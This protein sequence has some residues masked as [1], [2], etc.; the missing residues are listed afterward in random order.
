MDRRTN[1]Y[2]PGAGTPPPELVGRD[3][4]I[5]DAEIALDR[6]R[7][8][9]ATK[10]LLMV[11]LRGV[12]KTVLLNRILLDA[13]ER[14]FASVLIEAPEDRS[15]P[16]ALAGPLNSAFLQLSRSAAARELARKAR[17]SLAGFV[18]AMKV[19]YEDITF[20]VDLD[21]EEGVADSGDLDTDLAALLQVAG[22]AARASKTVLVLFID[23]MQYV[24]EKQLGA[25]ITALHRIA[26]RQLPVALIGSGLPQLVGHV[27]VAKSYAERMFSFPE[28]GP[29]SHDA[30]RK[31]LEAPANRLGVAYQSDALD[32]ILR[33]TEGY[34]Y[35][36]QE[37]GSACWT[38]ADGPTINLADV[39]AASPAAIG[40]L[41][42][43]FFRVRFERTT[44]FER[45]YL[46]AMAQ[47]GPG[48][49]RSGEI[50][51]AMGRL[52]QRVAPTRSNLI[53]KGMIYSPA[54][55]DTAFTVPLFD[56]Y[57]KRTIP[58]GS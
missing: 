44:P 53:K 34:P 17:R 8:G 18:R 24:P 39:E 20:S 7:N 14:G 25:L 37:W 58:D 19:S 1:P 32:Q 27:G 5:E 30:A 50:A 43:T 38:A 57:L 6:L 9:L 29:L 15:L 51:N 2:A 11:G 22:E 3:A 26:Q 46:R 48:P 23:E 52:V 4:L 42:S 12:G 47:L 41:D 16:A 33:I 40:E 55:G 13:E 35:F 56:Q 54:H 28:I 36:L 49:H 31:A 21:S 10:S 45:R